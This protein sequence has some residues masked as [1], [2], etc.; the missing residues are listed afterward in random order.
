MALFTALCMPMSSRRTTFA[1]RP[2]APPLHN[3]PF[4]Q[5]PPAASRHLW[6][7]GRALRIEQRLSIGKARNRAELVMGNAFPHPSRNGRTPPKILRA[8][9]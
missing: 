9:L 2:T 4:V 6:R 5:R 7:Q 8:A 1:G 3:P